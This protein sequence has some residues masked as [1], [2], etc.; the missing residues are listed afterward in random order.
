MKYLSVAAPAWA[1]EQETLIACLVDFESI[2]QCEFAAAADDIYPHSREIFQRAVEGEFGPI[3][4]YVPPPQPSIEAMQARVLANA[5]AIRFDIFQILDG[6]QASAIVTGAS[7]LVAGTPT[8]LAV[9][10]ETCKQELRD[11]PQE[12]DLSGLTTAEQMEA[13]I[14]AFYLGLVAAVPEEIKSAFRAIKP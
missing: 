3:A 13:A 6:L 11:L 2:G 5:R 1:N 9:V 12:V 14:V 10:I 7:V 4:P 8:P